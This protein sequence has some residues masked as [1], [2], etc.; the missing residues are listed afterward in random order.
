VRPRNVARATQSAI[1]LP[2]MLISAGGT[3]GSASRVNHAASAISSPS[4][5]ISPAAC[6]ARKPIMSECGNGHGWLP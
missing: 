1:I 4:I 3:S 6:S 5:A 2:A